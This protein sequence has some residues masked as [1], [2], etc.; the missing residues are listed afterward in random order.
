MG[1]HTAG[2]S[3]RS[4]SRNQRKMDLKVPQSSY[5]KFQKRPD[6]PPRLIDRLHHLPLHHH[7]REVAHQQKNR[8]SHQKVMRWKLF[9]KLQRLNQKRQRKRKKR[10]NK[11]R[12][13]KRRK[14][15]R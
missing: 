11:R 14:R 9:K 10:K 7:R 13:K 4:R 8:Q 3:I 1:D 15:R 5:V 12:K 6:L 2:E